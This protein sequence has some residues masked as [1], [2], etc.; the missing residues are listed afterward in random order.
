MN[1]YTL[2]VDL[3]FFALEPFYLALQCL[4]PLAPL[5][6]LPPPPLHLPPQLHQFLAIVGL[7]LLALLLSKCPIL[8]VHSFQLFPSILKVIAQLLKLNSPFL[9][10]LI[11]LTYLLL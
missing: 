9:L 1:E 2:C 4:D 8:L 6:T 10:L 7:L 3:P 11:Q 5:L